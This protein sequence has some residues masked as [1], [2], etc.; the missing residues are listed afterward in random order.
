[1]WL[2]RRAS[3][4]AFVFVSY[5]RRDVAAV[6]KL[7]DAL[8]AVM[9]EDHVFFDMADIQAGARW[10]SLL[11]TQVLASDVLVVAVSENWLSEF[12]WREANSDFVVREI[13]LA[14]QEKIP[15]IP[16]FLPGVSQ[17][18]PDQLPDGISNLMSYQGIQLDH[19]SW[20]DRMT[21]LVEAIYTAADESD[22]EVRRRKVNEAKVMSQWFSSARADEQAL[23][24]GSGIKD[25]DPSLIVS[26]VRLFIGFPK[27]SSEPVEL[28][29]EDLFAV[30][31]EDDRLWL[32][33]LEFDHGFE[34]LRTGSPRELTVQLQAQRPDLDV[35]QG[36]PDGALW[37]MR[38]IARARDRLAICDEFLATAGEKEAD[39]VLFVSP[40]ATIVFRQKQEQD[41]SVTVAHDSLGA[42]CVHKR[43]LWLLGPEGEH[44][45]DN[46]PPIDLDRVILLLREHASKAQLFRKPPDRAVRESL[47]VLNPTGLAAQHGIDL[48]WT[49]RLRPT[50]EESIV[51][52]VAKL[53]VM[54]ADLERDPDWKDRSEKR[55]T[56]DAYASALR[57]TFAGEVSEDARPIASLGGLRGS[58]KGED[59]ADGFRAT[60]GG[61]QSEDARRV[62]LDKELPRCPPKRGI[63]TRSGDRPAR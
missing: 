46:I 12:E 5:R 22:K 11:H 27:G 59:W 38:R 6:T 55:K 35:R 47:M 7:A 45:V 10:E 43:T 14:L 39:P 31:F 63:E 18:T 8:D 28:T 20:E 36:K 60:L 49:T 2:L 30:R 1:M 9:G 33:G 40:Q 34:R 48:S 26:D 13:S 41:G 52:A 21:E 62:L 16:V 42:V 32:L 3:K 24:R 53:H 15:V 54:E 23:A 51:L 37:Q 50:D 17:P 4:D 57:A 61:M 58:I 25:S 19:F 44:K 56:V 29:T